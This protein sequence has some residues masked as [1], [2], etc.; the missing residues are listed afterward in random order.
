MQMGLFEAGVT[1]E[2]I[3]AGRRHAAYHEAGHAVTAHAL[4]AH[5]ERARLTA[6]FNG[7]DV[8]LFIPGYMP[9]DERLFMCLV[10]LMAGPVCHWF[11]LNGGP[12]D[13]DAGLAREILFTPGEVCGGAI[14][15]DTDA[16]EEMDRLR[17]CSDREVRRQVLAESAVAAA[18]LLCVHWRAVE[19]FAEALAVRGCL[20]ADAIRQ[21][22]SDRLQAGREETNRVIAAFRHVIWN[23]VQ[24]GRVP[25]GKRF[26]P[27]IPA[28]RR[29]V[30]RQMKA[31]RRKREGW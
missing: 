8:S 20:D 18:R 5:V 6:Q 9:D 1:G 23:L 7:G 19:E 21:A 12:R 10:H 24:S 3:P 26:E 25:R 16:Q 29:T 13:V 27:A 28:W 31:S 15:D 17:F 30:L 4:G 11:A 2:D 22:I 14:G